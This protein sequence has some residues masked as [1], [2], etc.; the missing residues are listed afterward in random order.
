M[1][2]DVEQN[3][4]RS[5]HS[6]YWYCVTVFFCSI[7]QKLVMEARVGKHTLYISRLE[8]LIARPL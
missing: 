5:A 2:K 3:D 4:G 1:Q 8:C 7:K 6:F